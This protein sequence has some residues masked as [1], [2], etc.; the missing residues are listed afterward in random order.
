MTDFWLQYKLKII[1]AIVVA[2]I[3][4]GVWFY[5]GILKLQRDSARNDLKAAQIELKEWKRVYDILAVEVVKQAA[6][7]KEG[8]ELKKEADRKRIEAEKKASAIQ[9]QARHTENALQAVPASSGACESELETIK[10]LL[11]AHHG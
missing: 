11:G 3:V 10:Q 2:A 9:A 1:L 7:I 4:A 6:A 5:I 8:G